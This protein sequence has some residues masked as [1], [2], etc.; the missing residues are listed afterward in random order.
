MMISFNP[1]NHPICFMEPNLVIS[2]TWCEHI[3]FAMFLV[4]ILRPSV[5]VELGTQYGDSYC[6]FCQAVKELNIDAHCYAIYAGPGNLDGDSSGSKVF[7]DLRSYHDPNYGSFSKLVQSTFEEALKNFAEGTI[8]IMH[9]DGQHTYEVIKRYFELW[10]PKVSPDGVILLHNTNFG[11]CNFGVRRLWNELKLKYSHFE[12][13]HGDGLGV[14]AVGRIPSI[15]LREL[16]DATN[17]DAI[18]IR[19]FFFQL[20]HRL[21]LKKVLRER[22]AEIKNL[23]NTISQKEIHLNNLKSMIQ[24][25]ETELIHIYNSHG[26]K[27]LLIYYRLRDKIFPMDSKRRKVAKFILNIFLKKRDLRIRSSSILQIKKKAHDLFQIK[28]VKSEYTD[29][30]TIMNIET[31][32][33]NVKTILPKIRIA[34]VCQP[35]YFR[36]VYED[37]LDQ[38]YEVKEFMLKWGGN[39]HYYK[40][41]IKFNPHIAF[42][43]RPE[44]YP[45]ELLEKLK[46]LKVALSSEPIPKY[47]NNKFIT[48]EDMQLRFESLKGAKDK[49]YDYFFHFD[50]TSIKFLRENGFNVEGEFILPVAIGTYR[51]INC[52]KKWDWVFSGRDTRHRNRFLEVA[53]RDFKGLHLAHGIFSEEYVSLVNACKI[54]INLHVDENVSIEPRLQMLMACKVMVMSEPLS[55]NELFKPGIHYVEFTKPEEFWEKLRYYLEH[56]DEREKIALNGLRLVREYLSTKKVFPKFIEYLANKNNS[57]LEKIENESEKKYQTMHIKMDNIYLKD[58]KNKSV[59]FFIPGVGISGGIMVVCQHAN[60][61]IKKGYDVVLININP[62]DPFKLDWFPNL[63]AKVIPINKID[64]NIDIA[65]ATQWSTAY[66]VKNFPSKRKLYFVQ[67]NETRFYSPG[68]KESELAHKTYTFDFEFV[69]IARWIQKWLND[70]FNKSSY[71]VPNGVDH[72]IFYPDKPLF[73]KSNKLRVLLEGAINRPYKNM[74]EAFQ[75]VNGMDC[76]VWCVS[77]FGRPKPN[78][79]CDKFFENVSQEMMR[80]IYSSCDV[81]IKMSRVEGF[82]MPPL[83][84]MACGGTVILSKVTGYEEYI[85]DGYNALVVEEGDVESAREKLKLLIK[86]RELIQS[87]IKGGLETAQNWTWEYSNDR[88]EKIL[89]GN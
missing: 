13:L 41:L 61:L 22:E 67:S 71:Y 11:E 89:K 77:N 34:F 26:W 7:A 87:L 66:I 80:K 88:L 8:D 31:S 74:E 59:A 68:S 3:P 47:I 43:F 57:L 1:F 46:G 52:K 44:L 23:K 86:N 51:P 54:G 64:E 45:N 79:K 55:H 65:I 32:I 78:W 33:N 28:Q 62:N 16:F 14:L 27:G 72:S 21:Y 63:L 30:R 39:V 17:E 29:I 69:V 24:E 4:D 38:N 58:T 73:P 60:R 70:N 49:K 18:I 50:R 10:L 56:N 36:F 40:D 75:V 25:K 9:I 81:L 20:G 35:E 37:D 19:N 76:E 85:I 42:F 6:A 83:E 82:P 5:I 2:S 15:E 12:F 84:M 53:K 48:S